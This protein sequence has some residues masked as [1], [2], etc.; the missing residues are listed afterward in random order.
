MTNDPFL[1]TRPSLLARLREPDNRAD[2][3]QA[4]RCFFDQ[5]TPLML[6]WCRRWGVSAAD[7]EDVTASVLCHLGQRLKSFQYNPTHRFRG[8]LKTVVHN[9][10]RD[11]FDR[12]MRR[13]SAGR[14]VE[15]VADRSAAAEA[16]YQEIEARRECLGQA[17]SEVRPCVEPHTWEAFHRTAVLGRAAGEVATEL[18][19][20]TVAVYKAKSRVLELI[21]RAV[22]RLQE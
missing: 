21:R 4:W 7:A 16:L 17:M 12:Q 20:T 1:Q 22:D 11:F 15:D 5:Y 10:V 19:M 3:D 6:A 18:G 2:W 8:W 9:E 13:P 14:D